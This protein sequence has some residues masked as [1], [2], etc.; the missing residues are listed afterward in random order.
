MNI[1]QITIE[2]VR[3]FSERQQ[4]NIRPLTFLVGENSTGKTTSMAC[5]QVLADFLS[6][7]EV[8]FNLDPY[9]MGVFGEIVRRSKR[10]EKS[11]NIGF[12]FS[13]AGGNYELI[14]D[15]VE[16][17]GGVE[18]FLSSAKLKFDDGEVVFE[19]RDS[20]RRKRKPVQYYGQGS[21]FR[22]CLDSDEAIY[23]RIFLL[24]TTLTARGTEGQSEVKSALVE[25]IERKSRQHRGLSILGSLAKEP[26]VLSSS[27][28]RSRPRRTYDPLRDSADPEG[29]DAPMTM[30]LLES[31]LPDEWRS[32]KQHLVRFGE[33]S[34]LYQGIEVKNLGGS[35]GA[36]FQL[37]VKVR[38]PT[39]S[40]AHVGYGVSQILPILVKVLD[41]GGIQNRDLGRPMPAYFLLQQPEVHLHPKAQAEL[42]SL[43]AQLASNGNQ[44]FIVETHSDY[45]IDRA[46]IEIM[47]GNICNDDVSLIYLEPKRNIVKVHNIGFDKMGNLVNVPQHYRDF[48]L[49]ESSRLM[50]FEDL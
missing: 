14:A 49:L 18:P 33:L 29:G 20:S 27:P 24:L 8:D 10:T 5:F 12:S 1:T 41:F 39:V 4:F 25:Y 26:T 37:T 16:S 15:F 21:K 48:F 35:K 28:V 31:T 47:K 30:M 23:F 19:Y 7:G 32:L 46:R 44:S 50:G 11:F 2:E 17:E 13:D 9:S 22:I 40:I 38:G 36:P 43:F 45:M 3:C 42:S 34:G 6:R